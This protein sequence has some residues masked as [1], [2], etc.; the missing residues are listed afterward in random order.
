[1]NIAF[2]MGY[3]LKGIR[4]GKSLARYYRFKET[5]SAEVPEVDPV[6]APVAVS[7]HARK[8][9]EARYM[10]YDHELLCG[11]ADG[12]M[13]TR[14]H[15]GRHWLRLVGNNCQKS[16]TQDGKAELTMGLLNDAIHGGQR[17]AYE[18]LGLNNH[19]PGFGKY[20]ADPADTLDVVLENERDAM[21]KAVSAISENFISVDGIVH[22]ACV[23]PAIRLSNPIGVKGY[24]DGQKDIAIDYRARYIDGHPAFMRGMTSHP[25]GDWNEIARRVYEQA[26]DSGATRPEPHLVSPEVYIPESINPDIDARRQVDNLVKKAMFQYCQLPSSRFSG[27]LT[28]TMREFFETSSLQRLP[29]VEEILSIPGVEMDG[30]DKGLLLSRIEEIED[31][32]S[33]DFGTDLATPTPSFS[34]T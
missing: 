10:T 31:G 16:I 8:L 13:M 29:L 23:Q 25:V 30:Y 20:H 21:L 15:G 28:L 33:I 12:R 19:V 27:V 32:M 5:L 34:R 7:W 6:D 24:S 26:L 1:M 18:M 11:D 17:K 4:P 22:V 9:V 3:N 14:W 2:E